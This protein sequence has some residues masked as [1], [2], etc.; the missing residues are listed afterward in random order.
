MATSSRVAASVAPSQSKRSITNRTLSA[1]LFNPFFLCTL[2]VVAPSSRTAI[3]FR[4][5]LP[6]FVNRPPSLLL[7]TRISHLP[8]HVSSSRNAISLFRRQRFLVIL[9]PRHYASI[10]IIT[11]ASIA[12]APKHGLQQQSILGL[13]RKPLRRWRQPV[14]KRRIRPSEPLRTV[15][16]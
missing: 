14:R 3:I 12:L 2:V 4:R 5:A 7:D 8:P 6:S 10:L 11:R 13:R 15:V 9:L 1:C 16:R